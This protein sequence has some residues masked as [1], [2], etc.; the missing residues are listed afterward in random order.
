MNFRS[1]LQAL[2]D[3]V[4]QPPYLKPPGAPVLYIKPRNCWIGPGEPIPVPDGADA[5]LM[6]GTIGMVIGRVATRVTES[7]AMDYIE[8]LVL[9]NDVSLP[10]TS[11]F[12]P[13]LKARCQDGFLSI[14]S[15]MTD[16]AAI[17]RI[18]QLSVRTF[19][20]GELRCAAPLT[21]LV[22]KIPKLL[23][24]ITAFMTLS[25]GDVL[26]IGCPSGIP[27][28]RVG[29]RVRIEA[30]GF[31]PLENSLIAEHEIEKVRN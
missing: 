27:L 23:A 1:A 2:G 11:Y 17:A 18:E 29:D 31:E 20:N 4:N 6:G 25:P 3:A 21:G 30:D 16:R 5:L 9:A 7:H 14:A 22:R 24:D 8:G 19:V 13:P 12:R 26:L 28:A 15:R 10:E